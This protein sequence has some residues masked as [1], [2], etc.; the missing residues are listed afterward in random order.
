MDDVFKIFWICVAFCFI[1]LVW[2][3]VTYNISTNSM[4]HLKPIQNTE[5]KK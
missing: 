1:N 2:G 5:I 4:E 3:I